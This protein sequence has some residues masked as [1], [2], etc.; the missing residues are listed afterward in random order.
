MCITRPPGWTLPLNCFQIEKEAVFQSAVRQEMAEE[1]DDQINKEILGW[2]YMH[3]KVKDVT[4]RAKHPKKKSAKKKK[5][6]AGEA[7]VAD[8]ESA[9]E[10]LAG[11][12]I[13]IGVGLDGELPELMG[14]HPTT[15]AQDLLK[16]QGA[17]EI[18]LPMLRQRLLM[19]VVLPLGDI[20]LKREAKHAPRSVLLFG[21]E[22]C[23]KKTLVQLVAAETGATIFDIS[24]T[25]I[26][27]KYTQ[28]KMGPA[29]LM[30]TVTVAAK[31][32]A[33]SII[34][35]DDAHLYFSRPKKK[36]LAAMGGQDLTPARIMKELKNHLRRIQK[37]SADCPDNSRVVIICAT[38][39]P[40][41]EGVNQ[42]VSRV[43]SFASFPS[44]VSEFGCWRTLRVHPSTP[45][46]AH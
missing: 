36:A 16:H 21:P 17:I 40:F 13:V 43:T 4:K 28:P 3:E 1:V 10:K 23:G 14:A 39:C 25:N 11:E 41:Y 33:P 35:F 7:L 20:E 8:E 15:T 31:A 34:F 6:C 27:G 45:R 37:A 26:D 24:P 19:N 22:G 29:E 32:A 30:H 2:R 9:Y 12:G 5:C 18:P 42:K 46:G 44:L 38:S